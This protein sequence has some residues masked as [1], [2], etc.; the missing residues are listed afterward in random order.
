M[1]RKAVAE[2]TLHIEMLTYQIQISFAPKH[3]PFNDDIRVYL[4]TDHSAITMNSFL[5]NSF[6]TGLGDTAEK[7]ITI[8]TFH[9]G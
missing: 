3:F 6:L 5:K 4:V 9:I 2:F 8:V 7:H 1:T